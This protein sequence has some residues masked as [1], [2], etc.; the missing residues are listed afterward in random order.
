MKFFKLSFDTAIWR[1]YLMMVVAIVPFFIGVPYFA[2]LAAPVFLSIMLGIS[3]EKPTVRTED[4]SSQS[5]P[6]LVSKA[7]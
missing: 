3:F 2:V 4:A 6:Q 7:A 5:F 1:F